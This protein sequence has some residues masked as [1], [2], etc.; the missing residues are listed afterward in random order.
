MHDGAAMIQKAIDT[1][2][3]LARDGGV[4]VGILEPEGKGK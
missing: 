2:E 4:A 3:T 1:G